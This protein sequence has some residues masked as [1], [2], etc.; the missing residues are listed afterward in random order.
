MRE[1]AKVAPQFWIG[2]TGRQLRALGP[3]VQ[4]V[5]LYLITSPH[6]N[7]IGL[8]YLPLPLLCHETGLPLEGASKALTGLSAVGFAHFDA[9]SEMVWVVEMAHYQIGAHLDI[10]DNRV[11]GVQNEYNALPN[12]PFLPRFFERYGEVYHMTNPRGMQGP[13]KAL[14]SQEQEQEQKQEQEGKTL[15]SLS[16]QT[17]TEPVLSSEELEEQP[18]VPTVVVFPTEVDIDEFIE[19]WNTICGSERLPRK[20][21]P[22]PALRN[23]IRLRLRHRPDKGFWQ[24]VFNKIIRSTFLRGGGPGR[25]GQAPFRATLDWLV[26]N[27][28]NAVKVFEGAYDDI[29]QRARSVG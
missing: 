24:T 6:A 20:E 21:H 25:W 14:L 29:L 1:Y 17:S 23:K 8:Y 16:Q 18:K 2:E 27:D 15:S 19:G 26:A 10:K 13:S 4:L 5:A 11:K 28:E 12:N 9:P 7:M 22:T 3:E